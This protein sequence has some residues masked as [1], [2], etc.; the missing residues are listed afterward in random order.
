MTRPRGCSALDP[1]PRPD[2]AC[3]LTRVTSF[4][5]APISDGTPRAESRKTSRKARDSGSSASTRRGWGH[6]TVH[7]PPNRKPT[8]TR[9][10]YWKLRG[11]SRKGWGAG[12][13]E[14]MCY[15]R[16]GERLDKTRGWDAARRGLREPGGERKRTSVAIEARSSEEW[17]RGGKRI[18]SRASIPPKS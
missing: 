11:G 3:N 15:S 4:D 18:P 13:L 14:E 10:I 5:M 8:M 1:R 9:A 2:R 6:R 7:N 17:T 12:G 16:W